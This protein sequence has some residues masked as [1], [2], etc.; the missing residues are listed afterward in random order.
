MLVV[1]VV[2][3]NKGVKTVDDTSKA[4]VGHHG[5]GVRSPEYF[6]SNWQYTRW[7]LEPHW[8]HGLPY[9]SCM[10]LTAAIFLRFRENSRIIS[11]V[12]ETRSKHSRLRE[13]QGWFRTVG[14]SNSPIPTRNK[15]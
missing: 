13:Q 8:Q 14:S 3:R 1:L 6:R 11:S 7:T 5:R 4:A 10:V 2:D 12:S 9:H 15:Y